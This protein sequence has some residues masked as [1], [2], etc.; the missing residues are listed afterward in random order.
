MERQETVTLEPIRRAELR[1]KV[2]GDTPLLSHKF[3]DESKQSMVDKQRQKTREI[4]KRDIGS[5]LD[6]SI[7][8]LDKKKR[9]IGFPA[10]A[11]K[12]AMVEV[13]PYLKN[14]DKKKAKG[15]FFII[16]ES[17]DLVPV[18]YKEQVVNEA[19]VR[20]SG[21]QKIAFVRYRPEFRHW[22]CELLIRFNESQISVE[23]IVALAN[24]AG[25]HIGIG[26]WRP[27]C[28]GTYGMFKVDVHT[29]KRL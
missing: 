5:E 16:G 2:I 20:L 9:R 22:S 7:Y 10:S 27:Q 14:M 19:V 26:D 18:D 6:Q 21:P 13:A 15:S 1:I 4:K 28:S 17:N 23:Q 24:L 29:K 25:F 8:W 12:K 11:F 3:S